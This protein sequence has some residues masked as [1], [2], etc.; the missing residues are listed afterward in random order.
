MLQIQK[1]SVSV[2]SK[3]ILRDVDLSFEIGKTYFLLG[4]NG[5][6][7]SSLALALMGHPKYHIDA[8]KILLDGEDIT[9]LPP[10]ERN[11]K[12]MFLSFQN[13][14]EIRG[15]RFGEYLRTIYNKRLPE[16]TKALSP[17][18]F[19]RLVL[20]HLAELSMSEQFLERDLNVGFSGGEKRKAEILQV[21]LLSPRYILLDEIESGLDVDAFR[22]VAELLRSLSTPDNAMIVITHD[23]RTLDYLSPD[24]AIVLESGQIKSRGGREIVERIM[25]E[26]FDNE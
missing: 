17:F 14:P 21:R 6:G 19:R 23:A 3:S 9:E 25:A 1:L 20:P 7:K 4:Q 10:D 11:K 24:E 26:G 2:E 15:V 12:G 8:G 18:V 5:S 13:I 22:T 16:G